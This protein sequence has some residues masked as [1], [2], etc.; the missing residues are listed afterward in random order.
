M[1]HLRPKHPPEEA[2]LREERGRIKGRDV[3]P[4]LGTRGQPGPYRRAVEGAKVALAK[5]RWGDA[6]WS[7]LFGPDTRYR[8]TRADDD[9]RWRRPRAP[10]A[11]PTTPASRSRGR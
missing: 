7:Y 8:S 9:A 10:R 2:I 4:A 3:T 5:P 11:G 1:S 6:R